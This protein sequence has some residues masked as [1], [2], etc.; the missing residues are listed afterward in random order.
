MW[1]WVF[2]FVLFGEGVGAVPDEIGHVDFF[3][4]TGEDFEFAC[5]RDD[6]A[7][8][9]HAAFEIFFEEAVCGFASFHGDCRECNFGEK[10]EVGGPDGFFEVCF[11]AEVSEPVLHRGFGVFVCFVRFSVEEDADACGEEVDA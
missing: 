11:C 1:S 8:V 4:D 10:P 3:E 2:L 6:A 9:K 7:K 5:G